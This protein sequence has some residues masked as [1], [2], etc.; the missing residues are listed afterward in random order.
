[1]MSFQHGV[2]EDQ[3]IKVA[4]LRDVYDVYI[5]TGLVVLPYWIAVES[6]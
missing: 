6:E 4:K 3:N 5:E 2:N 1:M